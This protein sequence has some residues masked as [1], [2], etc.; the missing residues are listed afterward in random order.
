MFAD[1]LGWNGMRWSP[2]PNPDLR[3]NFWAR[4]WLTVG[5]FD[6]V[7]QNRPTGTSWKSENRHFMK[8]M[9]HDL[10]NESIKL[11]FTCTETTIQREQNKSKLN[12]KWSL[13]CALC[14]RHTPSASVRICLYYSPYIVQESPACIE[15][16]S[17]DNSHRSHLTA[18]VC[19]FSP[20]KI[21]PS[22]SLILSVKL[23]IW[24]CAQT[25]QLVRER[26]LN[27]LFVSGG[28]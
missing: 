7:G 15:N 23:F 1:Q 9:R 11:T 3:S 27:F 28:I 19:K 14:N 26:N 21:N 12:Q 8:R 4:C 24:G 25:R 6:V 20:L 16:W 5:N 10:N 18:M 13:S 17:G 2:L 22:L